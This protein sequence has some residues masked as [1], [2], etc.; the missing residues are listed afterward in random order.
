MFSFITALAVTNE[1]YPKWRLKQDQETMFDFIWG[2]VMP[3]V[4]LVFDPFVFK[5]DQEFFVSAE[6]AIFAPA[7]STAHFAGYS[8]PAYAFILSQW[9]CLATVLLIGRPP[10]RLAAFVSGVLASGFLFAGVLGILLF[11]PSVLGLFALGI[12][13]LGF[14]PLFTARAYYRRARYAWV[15]AAASPDKVSIR[16]LGFCLALALPLI[17]F[18]AAWLL[19]VSA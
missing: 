16:A 6:R 2:I 7:L 5:L 4:C 1:L 8:A 19:A 9:L 13:I 10:P 18:L 15:I 3:I 12:G 14:T 17:A 11:V